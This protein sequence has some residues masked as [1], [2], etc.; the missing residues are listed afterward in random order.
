MCNGSL[1][2]NR[3]HLNDV[4][5]LVYLV[6]G[7]TYTK[8]LKGFYTVMERAENPDVEI[9]IDPSTQPTIPGVQ[10]VLKEPELVT[11]IEDKPLTNEQLEQEQDFGRDDSFESSLPGEHTPL[12]RSGEEGMNRST[13][14]LSTFTASQASL[15]IP[16]V[17]FSLYSSRGHDHGAGAHSILSS[18]RVAGRDSRQQSINSVRSVN[19][20]GQSYSASILARIA[21]DGQ[22]SAGLALWNIINMINGSGG[23]LGAPYAV[24]IGGLPVLAVI[25]IVGLVTN[26]A[27]VLLID[28]LYK[29][30]PKTKL[31]KKVRLSY[32]EI[33]AAC[34]GPN[35]GKLVDIV[36]ISMCYCTTILFIIMLGSSMMEIVKNAS[37]I[38]L[39]EWCLICTAFV[40]P[41]VFIKK[42]SVLAWLSM[43]AVVAIIIV[44]FIVIGYCLFEWR[45]WD[46]HNI[47]TFNSK[48]F[49]VAI[50]II[51]F[52]YCGH[53]VFPGIEGSMRKPKK[54]NK[55]SYIA[56]SIVT[57]TKLALAFTAC[58]L[59]GSK[60]NPIVT[61][62]LIADPKNSVLSKIAIVLV[63]V[64]VY[65]SYPLNM[66]VASESFDIIVLPKISSRFAQ[67]GKCHFVWLLL[68]RFALVFGTFGIAVAVPNFGPLM[69]IFGS[70]LGA[71]ISFIFPALFHLKL[72]WNN[73][74][75][76]NKV[77]EI[78][79]ATFGVVAGVLG[80]IYSSIALKND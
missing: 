33:G 39:T 47:P 60:T 75:W 30:C 52:G 66:F 51:V 16:S 50:G 54:F 76:Y 35:G 21:H 69:A 18:S 12:L 10:S 24:Y 28:C 70:I 72:K 48:S 7:R 41:L 57:L 38:T 9:A 78:T 43:L 20:K 14:F 64:N 13:D 59:F 63:M 53:A 22:A 19:A 3:F 80:L 26:F 68:T 46:L 5:S 42:L 56:F 73:L 11:I 55:M 40:L 49:P 58:I 74:K 29:V 79:L 17:Q 1:Y 25:L 27:S 67:G 4:A 32:A 31:R 36:T 8:R 34:W 77:S 23:L 61:L 44:A 15:F 37:H 6:S 65:F 62:N 45:S 2:N 71:C